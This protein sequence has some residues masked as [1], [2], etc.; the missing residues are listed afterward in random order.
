VLNNAVASI[1]ENTSTAAQVKVAEIVV[2]DDGLGTNN[3]TVNG[4]DAGFFQI[5]GT[6]L[7]LKAGTPLS[8]ATK[9]SYS[10]IVSVDDPT[11]G[12]NPDAS[13]SFTLA[14]TASTGGTPALIIS[15]VAPWASGNSPLG[16]DWFEVTNIG[17]AAQNISGWKVD[18]NSNSFGSA[19]ALNGISSIAPGES[20]IFIELGSGHTA[21][22][23][24]TNFKTLWFGA[25]A[26]ANL[27]IGSYGGSGVGL[28]TGGDAL[29]LYNSAGVLQ[30]NVGFGVSPG[31]PFST[32]DNASGLNNTTISLLSAVGINGAFAAANHSTEIGSPGTI[33]APST[34]VVTIAAIDPSAAEAGGDPGAFRITRTGSTVGALTVN[35]TVGTGSGQATTAD[36]TPTLAGVATIASG[37]AFVDVTI[38]P[39]D[40][41]LFEGPETVILTLFD[42]GSYDVGVP[43]TAAVTI[44]DNDPPDTTI[45][46]SPANPTSS[47]DAHFTFSGSE[48]VAAITRFECSLDGQ[49]Y[50][51]CSSAVSYSS[52]TDGSHTFSVRAVDY[53]GNA[54]P[55]PASFTWTVDTKAPVV[56]CAATPDNLW[57]ANGKLIPVSMTVN[58]SD[59][60]SGPA[61]FS[62]VSATSSEPDSG[63]GDIQGFTTGTASVT[64]LLR[65]SRSGSGAGRIYTLMYSGSDRAGNTARCITTVPVPHDQGHG[66]NE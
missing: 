4:A 19:V 36:Y 13:T 46:S 6:A 28:S 12:N 5:T 54:D 56:T 55:T 10:V 49:S 37:Q 30:A 64:G 31:G 16:A 25:N 15:E 1:P 51:T 50:A 41:S 8:S 65:A 42:S 32:F 3:L 60:L 11:V 47:T 38:T 40:D 26:P 45:D 57:P 35:Y 24:A 7:F 27:R 61:G 66:R 53:S 43:S 29:N 23:D 39:V 18:D 2:A 62:L 17:T 52:L 34:P 14:V 22:G 48:P 58:V 9:P 44:A 33:G 20:V 59:A 21:P 63:V